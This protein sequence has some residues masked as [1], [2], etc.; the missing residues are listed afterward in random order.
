MA[1]TPNYGLPYPLSSAAV[2]NG[3]ADIQ[4]L[5]ERLDGTTLPGFAS[6]A[7]LSAALAAY[8]AKAIVDAKGDLIVATA[9]DTVA[10]LAVGTNGHVLTADSAQAAGVKWAAPA[11]G[12]GS[13]ELGYAQITAQVNVPVV[14]EASAV[15][16][17]TAPPVTC[18]GVA[19]ILVE[20]YAPVVQAGTGA[21]GALYLALWEGS[22]NFGYWAQAYSSQGQI[23]ISIP[24]SRRLVPTA[25]S[26]TYT[27]KA[28]AS[29]SAGVIY[30][31]VGN[32]AGVFHPAYVR[33]T[34][35]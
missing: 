2:A 20:F 31:G 5:A 21:S 24:A 17:V 25:G 34:R 6:D 16:V 23:N 28:W 18:D 29:A 1:T 13:A 35:A 30:A 14:A 7:E 32:A 27:V 8:V 3:A 12:G 9:A 15:T 22:T 10:R 33:I 11:G 26:H 4:A 19:A